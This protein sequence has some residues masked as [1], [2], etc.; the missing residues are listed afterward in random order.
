MKLRAVILGCGSSGGVPRIG[1]PDGRGDWGACDP[2][3]PRN[4]RMRCSIAIQRAHENGSWEGDLTTILIDTSPDMR[5]QLIGN[6]IRLVD[7][8]LITHDHADQTHGMDD[9]R[10]VALQN[11]ARVP[12]YIS[13]HTSPAIKHRFRYLFEQLPGSAY[14]A[15]LDRIEMPEDGQ[16]AWIDGPTGPIPFTPFLQ[17]H[18]RVPSHGFRCGPF[19][20]S[21]DLNDMEPE[22]W[23]I[24]EGVDCWIIDALQYKPHGSHLHLEKSLEFLERAGARTGV[25]TNLHVVMDYNTLAKEVPDNVD[26]AYDGMTIEREWQE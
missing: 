1:G 5:L 14:P 6:G 3:E 21:A 19:A 23:P 25:L 17:K 26:P 9:L 24:V 12:V 10:A 2:S 22:S 16:T 7:A 20:Y 11:M 18:G 8:V 4:R 15:I 13:E